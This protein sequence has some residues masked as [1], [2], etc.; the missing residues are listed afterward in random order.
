MSSKVMRSAKGQFLP[1]RSGNPGGMDSNKRRLDQRF[2][3]DTRLTWEKHGR[4]ALERMAKENPVEFVKLVASM[5]PKEAAITIDHQHAHA[6]GWLE[7]IRSLPPVGETE[8]R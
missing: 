4:Q 2:V 7:A 6:I 5:L 1:G 8:N 3:A